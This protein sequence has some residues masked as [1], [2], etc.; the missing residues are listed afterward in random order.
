MVKRS[1]DFTTARSIKL[2]SETLNPIIADFWIF[3]SET[4]SSAKRLKAP[5]S[6]T[7]GPLSR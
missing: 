7:G 3:F 2:L 4:E 6:S 5:Y 1:I